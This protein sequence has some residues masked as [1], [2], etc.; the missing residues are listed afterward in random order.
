MSLTSVVLVSPSWKERTMNESG[1]PDAQDTEWEA[2]QVV[3]K[4]LEL[5]GI[6]SVNDAANDRLIAAIQAW[7]ELLAELRSGQPPN[8]VKEVRMQAILKL[9]NAERFGYGNVA[10][11]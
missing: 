9:L 7:G 6:G 2:W 3:V 1:Q 5:R 11:R 8:V 10:P 4:E